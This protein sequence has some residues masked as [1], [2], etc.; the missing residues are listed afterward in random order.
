MKFNGYSLALFTTLFVLL[1][2][3]ANALSDTLRFADPGTT[4]EG[5]LLGDFVVVGEEMFGADV[6]WLDRRVSISGN[7]DAS[8]ARD[9][10]R[11]RRVER[12]LLEFDGAESSESNLGKRVRVV[13]TL[14]KRANEYH[15]TDVMM[16]VQSLSVLDVT[17]YE[18][19][20]S[21]DQGVEIGVV[22]TGPKGQ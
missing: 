11:L 14:H 15:Y 2:S 9:R 16:I 5:R 7:R 19:D 1:G 17:G 22:H 20:L 18:E 4:L 3:G 12:I 8:D 10:R 13:G 21:S 6:L